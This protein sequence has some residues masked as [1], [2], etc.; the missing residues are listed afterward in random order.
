MRVSDQR[1]NVSACCTR[2]I[3]MDG[4][5]IETDPA[6]LAPREAVWVGFPDPQSPGGWAQVPAVVV[7]HHPDGVGVMFSHPLTGLAELAQRGARPRT[8]QATRRAL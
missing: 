8:A 2:D 3:A 4:A 6:S 7:H 5:F 1:G